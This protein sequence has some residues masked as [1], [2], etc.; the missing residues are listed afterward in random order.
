VRPEPTRPSRLCRLSWAA[1]RTFLLVASVLA[2]AGGLLA[3]IARPL[4]DS[5]V[6]GAFAVVVAALP[7]CAVG[8]PA[9]TAQPDP[10]E[11]LR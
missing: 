6:L 8:L 11:E 9:A 7:L 1:G 3:G 5:V 10:I 2:L 4:S